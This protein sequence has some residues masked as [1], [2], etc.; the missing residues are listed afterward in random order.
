MG[1]MLCPPFIELDDGRWG[2]AEHIT[3]AM[4]RQVKKDGCDEHTL[5]QARVAK[6]LLEAAEHW[7]WP[8]DACPIRSLITK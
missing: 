4:W 3:V 6:A 8:E 7:G 5:A 1:G 2:L